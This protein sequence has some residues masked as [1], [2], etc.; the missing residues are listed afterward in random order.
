MPNLKIKCIIEDKDGNLWAGTE[1]GGL[2]RIKNG[3][4]ETFSTA[5]GLACDNVFSLHEDREGS[6]WIGTIKG[7]LDRLRDTVITPYTTREGLSH[8]I[9][10]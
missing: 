7:G 4:I 6:L 9:V 5:G 3:K 8:D 1:G 2:I 10:N